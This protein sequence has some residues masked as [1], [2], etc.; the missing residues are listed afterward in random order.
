MLFNEIFY[1]NKH[2]YNNLLHIRQLGKL[3]ED[4]SYLIE[5]ENSPTN[6]LGYVLSGTLHIEVY[7]NHH[8]LHTGNAFILP[9]H[10]KYKMYADHDYPP[11][12][13]WA[14]IRGKLFESMLSSLFDQSFIQA[15][16]NLEKDFEKLINLVKDEN[17]DH[18]IMKH[19]SHMMIDIYNYQCQS[20]TVDE[21]DSHKYDHYISQQIQYQF[22]V[23]KMAD[24]FHISVDKLNRT[25]KKDFN[26]T[27]YQY[28]Q[29]IR[30]DLATSL[31]KNTDLTIEDICRRLGFSNRN[32]FT[33]F[34][35]SKVN[36]PPATYRRKHR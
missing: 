35:I 13:L 3:N 11:G 29:T 34:F 23:K 28:Y 10:C 32:N 12:L 25:F 33:A 16:H 17:E 1:E 20:L 2:A 27:P 7:G 5:R 15:N 30:L 6:V 24:H 8:K 22:S 26:L 21:S 31:L 9:H 19:I 14:N 18:E 4:E 36:T